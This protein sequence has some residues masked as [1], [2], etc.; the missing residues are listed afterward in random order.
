MKSYET[1]EFYAHIFSDVV[2]LAKAALLDGCRRNSGGNVI[3]KIVSVVGFGAIDGV[4]RVL[5][6]RHV[7]PVPRFESREDVDDDEETGSAG[8]EAHP[9]EDPS[10]PGSELADVLQQRLVVDRLLS[11]PGHS[12]KENGK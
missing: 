3:R 12:V 6:V 8:N 5:A 10:L 11:S 2:K 4:G 9:E 1:N 7:T